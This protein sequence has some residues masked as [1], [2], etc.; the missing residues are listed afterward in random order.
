MY[1]HYMQRLPVLPTSTDHGYVYVVQRDSAYKIGF[2]RRGLRRRVSDARGTLVLAIHTGQQPSQLEY[3]IN[4]VFNLLSGLIFWG[5]IN[6]ISKRRLENN[7]HIGTLN[8]L[9]DGSR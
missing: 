8:L 2:T 6:R 1:N 9:G 3:L 4:E 5:N 7:R